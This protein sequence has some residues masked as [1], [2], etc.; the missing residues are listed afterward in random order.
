M[1]ILSCGMLWI[2][3]RLMTG[4]KETIL[5]LFD[6]SYVTDLCHGLSSRKGL[7][8]S[9][10]ASPELALIFS[11]MSYA[12]YKREFNGKGA[13]LMERSHITLV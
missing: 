10:A 12:F 11:V 1:L 9:Q 13:Y 6:Y 5:R 7:T 4:C 2:K 3:Y 8:V